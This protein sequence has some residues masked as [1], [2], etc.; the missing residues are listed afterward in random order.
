MHRY[1]LGT[2]HTTAD[3]LAGIYGSHMGWFSLVH[4]LGGVGKCTASCEA[5]P[6]T[7][8]LPLQELSVASCDMVC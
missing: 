6:P 4:G 8:T 3:M 1:V 7:T 5:Q 2:L